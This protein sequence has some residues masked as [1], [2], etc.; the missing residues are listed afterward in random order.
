MTEFENIRA[1]MKQRNR[2]HKREVWFL[3][4]VQNICIV[5]K[6]VDIR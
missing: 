5:E 1:D 2:L 4:I 6:L 3:R